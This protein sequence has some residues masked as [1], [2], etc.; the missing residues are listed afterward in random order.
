MDIVYQRGEATVQEILDALPDPPSYSSVRASVR[1]L[2]EKGRLGHTQDGPRYVYKP[3]VARE[4]AAP[5][6]LRHLV[7]TF[8]RGSATE[9]VATLLEMRGD[10]MTEDELDELSAMIERARKEGK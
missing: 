3:V 4:R 7:D 8:F 5:S 6:A 2:E 9:A 1:I 10:A